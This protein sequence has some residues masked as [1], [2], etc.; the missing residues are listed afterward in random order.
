ME[1]EQACTEMNFILSNLNSED[2]KKIPDSFENFFKE[3]MDKNYKVN[4]VADKPLYEQEL[5]EETKAFIKILY[6]NYLAP[7]D[8]KEKILEELKKEEETKEE[9]KIN[10]DIFAS[11]T[12][13]E[14][15]EEVVQEPVQE[16][17]NKEMVIYKENKFVSF[18]KNILKKLK[19][20][21]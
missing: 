20:I 17:E 6:I 19:I 12:T 7:K 18:I 5:K 4:L 3:N 21:K 11:P 1:F 14:L 15:K 8:K 2:L 16:V 13:Q 9:V 10:D